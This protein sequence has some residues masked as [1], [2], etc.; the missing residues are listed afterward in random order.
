MAYTFATRGIIMSAPAL[1]ASLA[2]AQN[3]ETAGN[4][5]AFLD[6]IVVE[7]ELQ[8]RTLVCVS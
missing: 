7:G 4:T 5:P 1:I 2:V 8:T 6:E 3:E